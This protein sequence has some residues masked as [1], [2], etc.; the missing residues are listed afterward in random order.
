MAAKKSGQVT[1]RPKTATG[2]EGRVTLAA[3]KGSEA[4]AEW[5]RKAS[6]KSRLPVTTMIDVALAQ[7][8]ATNGIDPPPSR[9]GGDPE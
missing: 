3:F 5:L 6:M 4:Y 9:L 8:A 7:W 1:G 2:R